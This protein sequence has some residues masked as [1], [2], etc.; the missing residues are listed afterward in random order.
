FYAG[1]ILT[2]VNTFPYNISP[3]SS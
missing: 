1:L 3:A 2:L